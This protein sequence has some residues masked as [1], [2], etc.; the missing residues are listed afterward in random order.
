MKVIPT[1]AC[2]SS[3]FSI[4][5]EPAAC[6]QIKQTTG[7]TLLN[8]KLDSLNSDLSSPLN[9]HKRPSLKHANKQFKQ[10]LKESEQDNPLTHETTTTTV[11]A[12]AQQP[13]Y[14]TL[15][16]Y[17]ALLVSSSHGNLSI[18]QMLFERGLDMNYKGNDGSTKR[19]S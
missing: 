4:Y 14:I 2:L 11:E 15:T 9:N 5:N 16:P 18:I 13:Q 8:M 10:W 7:S 17:Q 3:L 19:F 12:V 6:W 1:L